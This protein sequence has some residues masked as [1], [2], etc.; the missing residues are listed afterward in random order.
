MKKYTI[1][2]VAVLTLSMPAW[3]TETPFA[4][5]AF[6][7]PD[8]ALLENSPFYFSGDSFLYARGG[9]GN[10]SGGFGETGGREEQRSSTPLTRL[11][12][13]ALGMSHRVFG[14]I[15]LASTFG[16]IVTGFTGPNILHQS[17]GYSAFGCTLATTATGLYA[18]HDHLSLKDGYT[19][20]NIHGWL[21]L[22]ATA[23]MATT[24]GL[25]ASGNSHAS[26]GALGGGMVMSFAL[27]TYYIR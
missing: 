12:S 16:A 6:N 15:T 22:L 11:N 24:V 27:F 5:N 4:D 3:S 2:V 21:G 10:R 14:F 7:F 18:F 9:G 1:M 8:N 17:L 20:Y 25:G 23:A 26:Y 13:G 19:R